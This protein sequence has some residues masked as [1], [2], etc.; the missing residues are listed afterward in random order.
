MQG[1]DAGGRGRRTQVR[2][3]IRGGDNDADAA[4]LP[5]SAVADGVAQFLKRKVGHDLV[6]VEVE[7][8]DVL[9]AF[10]VANHAVEGVAVASL[11][12]LEVDLVSKKLVDTLVPELLDETGVSELGIRRQDQNGPG[13]GEDE[14][15]AR[16]CSHT[17]Y[18]Q[19]NQVSRSCQ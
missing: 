17:H 6:T 2:R 13:T 19:G 4:P 12:G 10:D 3:R 11:D 8:P 14:V 5:K 18:R 15:G 1:I 9:G 16:I 7:N